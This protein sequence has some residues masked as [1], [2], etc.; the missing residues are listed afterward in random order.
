MDSRLLRNAITIT[1]LMLLLVFAAVVLTNKN[2]TEQLFGPKQQE[3]V[4]TEEEVQSVAS[5]VPD[6]QVGDDLSAFLTD[7][8]FF[9]KD[10][11]TD[12]LSMQYGKT[13][14]L[15]MTSVEKDLRI[16][17]VDLVGNLIENE[18]FCV[19]IEGVG[20]YKDTDKDGIIYIKPLKAGEYHVTLKPIKGYKVP[21]SDTAITVKQSVEYVAIKDIDLL[22]LT[23]EEIDTAKEDTQLA[24]ALEDRDDTENTTLQTTNASAKL[25]IDVSKWNKEIDWEKVKEAGI[26]YAIV[27]VGYRGYTTGS[28][29]EDPYFKTNIENASGAGIEVGVY[30][31]SQA[32]NNV[33]AVEE[34][35][36]VISL[37]EQ[38]HLDYPVYIDSESSGSTGRA[39][40]LTAEER[41]T[42]TQ[43]F[44]ETI[45]SAGYTAGIY[46]ARNW[47][48]TRLNMDELGDYTIWLA[49]YRDIPQYE[50]YYEMWQY[51]SRGSIDGITGNVDLNISYLK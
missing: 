28:L 25:G 48:N 27:R 14:S 10:E 47:L 37:C 8:S 13:A 17:V 51:T 7:E 3:A 30:F 4:V 41:T 23:E 22:I 33:E 43:A 31:F 29:I 18:E 36:M 19:S 34:A 39:D 24:G 9:D 49:E 5:E 26:D 44:C 2:V 42:V 50:G 35:S 1:I 6:K 16:H 40:N 11:N 12:K 32:L 38:Y 15:F 20:E 45:E 46:G 21:T